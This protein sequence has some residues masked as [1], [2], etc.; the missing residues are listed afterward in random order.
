MKFLLSKYFL[1]FQTNEMNEQ[2]ASE[3]S[4]PADE[5]SEITIESQGINQ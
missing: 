3:I 1:S 4:Y 2:S 5:K